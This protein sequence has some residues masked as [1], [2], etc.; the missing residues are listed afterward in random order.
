MFSEMIMSLITHNGTYFEYT[1]IKK[2]ASILP[3][4]FRVVGD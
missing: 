2:I 3:F 1:L 4:K